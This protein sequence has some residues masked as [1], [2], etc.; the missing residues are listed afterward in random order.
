M[1]FTF[2]QALVAWVLTILE[3]Q[4]VPRRWWGHID[5]NQEASR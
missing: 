5:N 4:F 3:L 1:E 2:E